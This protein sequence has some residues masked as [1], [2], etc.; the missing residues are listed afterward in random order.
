MNRCETCKIG[1]E[2][3]KSEEP[4]C[5]AWFL[6][7]VWVDNKSVDTCPQYVPLDSLQKVHYKGDCRLSGHIVSWV[8]DDHFIAYVTNRYGTKGEMLCHKDNWWF[9]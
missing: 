2:S 5:C 3:M 9:N 8:D 1:H 6:W 7:N 4:A